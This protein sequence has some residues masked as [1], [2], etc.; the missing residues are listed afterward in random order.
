[1]G[2]LCSTHK[3]AVGD[4]VGIKPKKKINVAVL[5]NILTILSYVFENDNN[6]HTDC[7]KMLYIESRKPEYDLANVH[8]WILKN[9]NMAINK[10]ECENL[11]LYVALYAPSIPTQFDDSFNYVKKKCTL[12]PPS[13]KEMKDWGARVKLLE[14]NSQFARKFASSTVSHIAPRRG[15][16]D[17]SMVR[18]SSFNRSNM[19]KSDSFS[20]PGLSRSSSFT[21]VL[22]RNNSFSRLGKKMSLLQQQM[23]GSDVRR[24]SASN[25]VVVQAAEVNDN[26]VIN[27]SSSSCSQSSVNPASST[28]RVEEAPRQSISSESDDH[29]YNKPMSTRGSI[30]PYAASLL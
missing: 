29:W 30:D 22:S 12:I 2:A 5:G 8:T 26:A 25:T 6:L 20:K 23:S 19:G 21:S 28:P 18:T 10:K 17:A 3:T 24:T 15:Y 7:L 13:P 14:K 11:V 16:S 4:G 27:R 1:M 9:T